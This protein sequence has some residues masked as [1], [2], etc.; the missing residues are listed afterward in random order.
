[1]WIVWKRNHWL[2]DPIKTVFCGGNFRRSVAYSDP[3]K[4]NITNVY[5]NLKLGYWTEDRYFSCYARL[6]LFAH[7][8]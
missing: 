1:M 8:T 6:F 5:W 4:H 3:R 2:A 7:Q